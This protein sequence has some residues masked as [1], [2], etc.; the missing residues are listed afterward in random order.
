MGKYAELLDAVVRIAARFH[1]HCPQTARLYYHPPPPN[2]QGCDHTSTGGSA[3][4]GL[5]THV[6]YLH[7]NL[8][9]VNLALRFPVSTKP[10]L[11]R[12]HLSDYTSSC[13]FKIKLKNFPHQV[14]SILV[15]HS[16]ED[17]NNN[18]N[19]RNLESCNASL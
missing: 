10:S 2:S 19:S 16:K 4:L 11:S 5:K 7:L 15:L 14:G 3:S 8:P 17:T 9:V 1:S 18:R 12:I 13:F 6:Q